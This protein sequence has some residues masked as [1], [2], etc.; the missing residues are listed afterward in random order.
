VLGVI[1]VLGIVTCETNDP[2]SDCPTPTTGSKQG[3]LL[4]ELRGQARFGIVYPC[5]LPNPQQLSSTSLQGAAG[6]QQA[7]L[8]FSGPFDLTIRQAQIP[9]AVS[10]DPAGA[11]KRTVDL[12]PN[13]PATFIE[14]NDGTSK[15]LYHLFW[16]ANGIY[17]E[18]QALGPP[19]QSQTII[20]VARSLQ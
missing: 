18:V 5:Y 17:Y 8:V 16:N 11:S 14:R 13:T 2:T 15:A 19:L 3:D 4:S 6:R 20:R 1:A 12:F 7:E 9:P 10:P